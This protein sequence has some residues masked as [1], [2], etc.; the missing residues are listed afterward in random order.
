MSRLLLIQGG[1]YTMIGALTPVPTVLVAD[2]PLTT[3]SLVCLAII[4]LIS[5][6]NALKAFLSTTFS[7]SAASQPDHHPATVGAIPPPL[8]A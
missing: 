1:L 3:R 2:A 4:A 8:R 7:E 6:G 5:G